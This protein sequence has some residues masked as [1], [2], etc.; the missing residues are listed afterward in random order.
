MSSWNDLALEL[1]GLPERRTGYTPDFEAGERP[2]KHHTG[3]MQR[4]RRDGSGECVPEIWKDGPV[5]DVDLSAFADVAPLGSGGLGDVY[6]ATRRSTGG[7]VAIKVLRD[8]SDRDVAWQRAQRELSALVDLRGHPNVVNVEEVIDTDGV[9]AIVME[10]A[11]GGSVGDL[12]Q[13]NGGTLTFPDTL[14]IVTQTA[15][16]LAAAHQLGIIHRDIKPHNLLI[17]TF[18]Q[19]KVCDF[20]IAALT[21]SDDVS[22]RTSSL[23]FRYASPEELRG[24]AEVGPAADVYSLAATTHQLLTGRYLPTPDGTAG[25]LPLRNWNAPDDL[26]ADVEIDFRELITRSAD[27]DPARR[28]TAEDLHER[29]E[30]LAVRLG[31]ARSRTLPLVGRDTDDSTQVRSVSVPEPGEPSPAPAVTPAAVAAATPAAS[32]PGAA[33]VEPS[34]TVARTS[35]VREDEEVDAA[36]KRPRVLIGALVAVL[37]LLVGGGTA[38]QLG[39]FESDPEDAAA[40]ASSN[41]VPTATTTPE[42]ATTP[43]ATTPQATTAPTTAPPVTSAPVTSAPST[44]PPVTTAPATTEPATTTPPTTTLP[45]RYDGVTCPGAGACIAMSAIDIVDGEYMF[46]WDRAWN[47]DFL[48]G[49]ADLSYHAHFFWD[50]YDPSQVGTASVDQAPWELTFDTVFVPTE[51]MRLANR[52][53]EANGICVTPADDNHA[54][55]DPAYFHCALV[56]L[57]E[58]WASD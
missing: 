58:T 29:F 13:T 42:P 40:G 15:A 45:E 39:W 4:F 23:S 55:I 44:S 57:G 33:A 17:G 6:R 18:G 20:G 1:G 7:H 38:F 32:A 28:P 37:A 8:W 21:R 26:P 9:L 51:E 54:V 30:A 19:V 36:S 10:Y 3:A 27:R 22:N 12:L 31:P 14:L 49:P 11:P 24:E 47:P 48:D 46:T 34:A 53:P 35:V 56:P 41:A 5:A 2:G 50:I 25:S 16:A 43:S 52:P